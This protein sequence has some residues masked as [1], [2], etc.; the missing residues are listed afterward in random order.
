MKRW[1]NYKSIRWG[2]WRR[3]CRPT[4]QCLQTNLA[5]ESYYT[6]PAA[7]RSQAVDIAVAI[8]C[9]MQHVACSVLLALLA[10]A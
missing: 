10:V 9:C 5:H 8:G 3:N 2:K 4:V 7:F 6:V 1:I